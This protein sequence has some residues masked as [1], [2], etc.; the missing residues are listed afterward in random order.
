MSVVRHVRLAYSKVQTSQR[1]QEKGAQVRSS[2]MAAP[3]PFENG[4]A[5]VNF[6]LNAKVLL[7]DSD[8]LCC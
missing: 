1:V 7:Y 2:E 5:Y 8:V 4:S 3:A 6:S